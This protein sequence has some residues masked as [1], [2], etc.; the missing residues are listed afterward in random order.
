MEMNGLM[1]KAKVFVFSESYEK[2]KDLLIEDQKIFVCGKPSNQNGDADVLKLVADD[3]FQLETTRGRLSRN[4]NIQ[5][6]IHNEDEKLLNEINSIAVDNKG[7]CSLVIHLLSTQ[8]NAK[9]VKAGN[10]RI[11]PDVQVVNKLRNIF[12]DTNVWVS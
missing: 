6:D 2:N 8:G 4:V 7:R 10:I 12:G 11:A 3:I 1:G 9:R 5:F